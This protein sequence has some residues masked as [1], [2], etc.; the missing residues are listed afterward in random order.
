MLPAFPWYITLLFL[1]SVLLSLYF[2]FKGLQ[3]SAQISGNTV[4]VKAIG[5]IAVWLALQSAL[6]YIGFYRHYNSVPPR[7]LLAV[8]PP[9]LVILFLFLYKPTLVFIKNIP[10]TTLTWLHTVRILVEIVLYYCFLHSVVPQIMTF[11]GRNFDIIAGLTAPLVAYFGAQKGILQKRQILLW[12]LICLGFLLNI[13]ITAVLSAPFPFQQ[14]GFA[15]P[16]IAVFYFPFILLP[17]F[18]VPL[19]LFAH[20]AAIAKLREPEL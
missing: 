17:A 7:F 13:V 5:L 19:V 14:F 12:N 1:I 15:Q 4:L 9:L 6:G 11:G 18:V 8:L 20:L 10:L 3:Q 16:N 2:L